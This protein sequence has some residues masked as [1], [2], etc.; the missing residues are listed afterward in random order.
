MANTATLMKQ[1]NLFILQKYK[2]KIKDTPTTATI[3]DVGNCLIGKLIEL[4]IKLTGFIL[5]IT[6]KQ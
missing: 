3:R 1:G 4:K 5:W 2:L 6:A